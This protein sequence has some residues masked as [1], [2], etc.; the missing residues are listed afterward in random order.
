MKRARTTGAAACARH[1]RGSDTAPKR[2]KMCTDLCPKEDCGGCR[3]S[4]GWVSPRVA[5]Q[6]EEHFAAHD[7]VELKRRTQ[8]YAKGLAVTY[9]GTA[10]RFQR[11]HTGSKHH[12]ILASEPTSSDGIKVITGAAV[13]AVSVKRR[14]CGLPP[15]ALLQQL[16]F[17][18]AEFWQLRK[19][20]RKWVSGFLAR[21]NAV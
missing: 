1:S 18:E 13:S 14:V 2:L 11:Y 4:F 8:P 21:R 3:S 15:P 9:K 10:C 6:L 16:H 12:C 20:F 17:G 19:K 5:L 7:K